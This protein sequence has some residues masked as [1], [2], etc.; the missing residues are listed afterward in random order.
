MDG[1]ALHRVKSD[2]TSPQQ[3]TLFL[4]QPE[5][6]GQGPERTESAS[7]AK[8]HQAIEGRLLKA[9]NLADILINATWYSDEVHNR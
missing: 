9:C 4:A 2:A 8:I 5:H 7:E 6:L 3:V 1:L